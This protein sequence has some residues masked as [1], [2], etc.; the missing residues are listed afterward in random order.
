MI[1]SAAR[2]SL[3]VGS[4][5]LASNSAKQ[6]CNVFGRDKAVIALTADALKEKP[7]GFYCAA[8]LPTCAILLCMNDFTERHNTRDT[9]TE[10][11]QQREFVKELM[12]ILY[13]MCCVVWELWQ[14]KK[15]EKTV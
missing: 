4:H 3:P 2:N 15:E 7:G 11:M 6:C 14:G 5:Q 9:G 1:Q 8:A 13:L 10:E 12:R